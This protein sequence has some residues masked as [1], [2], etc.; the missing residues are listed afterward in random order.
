MPKALT[1]VGYDCRNFVDLGW[2]GKPDLEWLPWVGKAQWL[3]FSCNKKQLIVPSECQAII[4]NK[5]GVIYL[6]NG[7]EYPAKV[8]RLLLTKWDTLKLLWD[9]TER[10][11]ARFIHPNGKI[12]SKYRNLE[13][14]HGI[15][16]QGEL[17]M[18]R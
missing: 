12:T 10:P 3:L 11:F 18:E 1:L 14:P 4:E 13:L 8:L 9:T 6:T 15:M 17:G 5:V 2:A 7:E 16:K